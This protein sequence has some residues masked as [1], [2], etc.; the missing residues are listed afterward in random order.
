MFAYIMRCTKHYVIVH[1]V[2]YNIYFIAILEYWVSW[3]F[4][5]KGLTRRVLLDLIIMYRSFEVFT[6][7]YCIEFNCTTINNTNC[8]VVVLKEKLKISKPCMKL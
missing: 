4:F 5:F 2:I 8:G 3:I 7:M 6:W 1:Y